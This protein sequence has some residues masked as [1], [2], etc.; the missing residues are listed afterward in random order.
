M[1]D[2]GYAFVTPTPAT[3]AR[4][5]ARPGAEWSCDLRDVFGWSRSFREGTVPGPIVAVMREAGVVRPVTDGFRSTIRFSTLDG[6]LFA[7]SAYPTTQADAVFFGPDTYRFARAILQHRPARVGRAVDI[8][9]GAGAGAI[10][11]ARDWPG[12]E[13]LAVDINPA[14]LRMTRVNA[15][16]AGVAVEALESDLFAALMASST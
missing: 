3:I 5:N 10:L 16:L 4:V 2:A 11:V 13:V 14:A 8:G 15:A 12:A 1:R 6:L 9:C 7:H